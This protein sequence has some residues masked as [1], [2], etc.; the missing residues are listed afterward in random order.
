MDKPSSKTALFTMK[1]RLKESGQQIINRDLSSLSS[2]EIF[3]L[4]HSFSSMPSEYLDSINR[5]KIDG[6]TLSNLQA[7]SDF[8][9]IGLLFN[10]EWE[11]VLF[12][13]IQ[14]LKANGISEDKLECCV[15]T[16]NSME[17]TIHDIIIAIKTASSNINDRSSTEKA[18]DLIALSIADNKI[19]QQILGAVYQIEVD[20]IQM[21][22]HYIKSPSISEKACQAIN[23]LCIDNQSNIARMGNHG[24]CELILNILKTHMYIRAVIE[25]AALTIKSLSYGNPSNSIKFRTEGV[26]EL[27]VEILGK[28]KEIPDVATAI[29]HA[30]RNLSFDENMRDKLGLVTACET[31]ITAMGVLIS[32]VAAVEAGCL[33]LFNLSF[34]ESNREKMIKSGGCECVTAALRTHLLVADNATAAC[35]VI[36]VLACKSDEANGKISHMETCKAVVSILIAHSDMPSTVE[37]S[38]KVILSLTAEN[39]ENRLKFASTGVFEAIVAVIKAHMTAVNVITPGLRVLFVLINGNNNDNGSSYGDS[40]YCQS[41]LRNARIHEVIMQVLRDHAATV[42]AIAEWGCRSL[43]MIIGQDQEVRQNIVDIDGCMIVSDLLRTHVKSQSVVD[44]CLT[45]ITVLS[46]D[47]LENASVALFG[48]FDVCETVVLVLWTY[49]SQPDIVTIG[50][51]VMALLAETS[52]LNAMKLTDAGGCEVILHLL[53]GHRQLST[54]IKNGCRALIPMLAQL[55]D[56][57]PKL[58]STYSHEIILFAH[59]SNDVDEGSTEWI[60]KILSSLLDGYSY[61]DDVEVQVELCEIIL[62]TMNNHPNHVSILITCCQIII[63]L[64]RHENYLV[65]LSLMGL[66]ET[67]VTALGSMTGSSE[68][69]EKCCK[70]IFALCYYESNKVKFGTAGVCEMISPLLQYHSSSVV[71]VCVICKLISILAIKNPTNAAK[72][73][74]EGARATLIALMEMHIDAPNTVLWALKALFSLISNKNVENTSNAC[75]TSMGLT[76]VKTI[77]THVDVLGVAEWG[78]R[79]VSALAVNNPVNREELAMCGACEVVVEVMKLHMTIGQVSARSLNA[80]STL[81]TDNNNNLN[82]FQSM[83]TYE[84]CTRAFC[85]NSQDVSVVKWGC[86]AILL[87]TKYESKSCNGGGGGNGAFMNQLMEH[88]VSA[89]KSHMTSPN[90]IELLCQVILRSAADTN[91]CVYLGAYGCCESI[92]VALRTHT[93]IPSC[94]ESCLLVISK[95]AVADANRVKLVISA[96]CEAVV[97]SL[98]QHSSHKDVILASCQ[99]IAS[100]SA[101]SSVGKDILPWT[102]AKKIIKDIAN[103]PILPDLVKIEATSTLKFL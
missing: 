55:E 31:V 7:S 84:L 67:F 46:N 82:R 93:T 38:L 42:S 10:R 47:G 59:K 101:N 4:M 25:A 15:P 54:V 13:E 66:C 75:T 52:V 50:T 29:F 79:V 103:N 74:K 77:Q 22:T 28:S 26:C 94:V 21:A 98:K 2:D 83:Q 73:N 36:S 76:I 99:A 89:M 71:T 62:N 57:K 45:L 24:A 43:S 23:Q 81:L 63:K 92:V 100:L 3:V 58:A 102:D 17:G 11:L 37:W 40:N 20:I 78:C 97:S 51:Q 60:L 68:G 9:S 69:V 19:N 70:V 48:D 34:I 5:K 87:L 6:R 1:L 49:L 12:A 65:K 95:L 44:S 91:L 16:I 32:H 80:V 86:K 18:F 33:A 88:A 8:S 56:D 14:A 27:L 61:V 72:I 41:K 39:K 35:K 96:A 53:R 30:I 90:I 64:S 85:A